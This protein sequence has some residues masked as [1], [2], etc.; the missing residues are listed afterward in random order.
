MKISSEP[1]TKPLFILWEFWR[2][3]LKISSEI[4]LW[5]LTDRQYKKRKKRLGLESLLVRNGVQSCE[6]KK[7]SLFEILLAA[8]IG[9]LA[10]VCRT[11]AQHAWLNQC[12][13]LDF[14]VTCFG[15]R[16]SVNVTVLIAEEHTPKIHRKKWQN[17][18]TETNCFS[19]FLRAFLCWSSPWSNVDACN[20]RIARNPSCARSPL[21]VRKKELYNTKTNDRFHTYF[22]TTPPRKHEN[23]SDLQVARKF[24]GSQKGGFP[25]GGFGK[26]SEISSK[27][28][29]PDSATLAEKAI[30]F[31]I[32]DART[33]TFAKAT[34]LQNRPFSSSWEVIFGPIDLTL[35][36]KW[37]RTRGEGL[38][39]LLKLNYART[40]TQ[41]FQ[42][43][44]RQLWR[45]TH[46]GSPGDSHLRN[47]NGNSQTNKSDQYIFGNGNGNFQQNHSPNASFQSVTLLTIIAQIIL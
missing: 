7:K 24:R 40:H 47:G 39:F 21:K 42:K 11:I 8:R 6:F 15:D 36:Q 31:D 2:S 32:L 1:P 33:G 35:P 43:P 34:L 37:F 25:K 9:K 44:Q 20:R 12:A 46:V 23:P 16:F 29:F 41:I 17:N 14:C 19:L 22:Y 4:F 30:I 38:K 28:S 26:R 18:L 27:K 5:A 13:V 3:R 45:R 10:W